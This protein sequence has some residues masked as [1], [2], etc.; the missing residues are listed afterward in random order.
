MDLAY[1]IFPLVIKFY[2][3]S[4]LGL[5][6]LV[7]IYTV[8][9]SVKINIFKEDEQIFIKYIFLNPGLIMK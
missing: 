4:Y 7:T 5:N 8:L 2:V 1:I 9:P 3:H 6:K